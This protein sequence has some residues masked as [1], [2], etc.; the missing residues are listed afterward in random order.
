MTRTR[1]ILHTAKYSG[2]PLDLLRQACPQGFEVKTLDEATHEQ[3]IQEASEAQFFLVSGRLPIDKAVLDNAPHLKMIQR[4]GVGTEMLDLEEIKRRGIPVYVNAGVNARSVAEHT[5]TLIL[6]ALKR[7]P[8]INQQVHQGIW[9][10]QQTG[11]T[12]YELYGKTVGLVGMGNIGRMVAGMLQPFGAKV[13]YTDVF[14]QNEKVE[15]ELGLTYCESFSAMLPLC[16]ILSFHCP[17]TKE[18]TEILNKSTLSLMKEGA[19]VVNTA[20]G[21]LIH[22]DDLYE[23]LQSGHLMGAALDTHYEE[24]LKMDCRLMD[25]DNVIMTPHIGGLSH[26]AFSQ[27]LQKAMTNIKAFEEGD[28]ERISKSKLL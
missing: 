20:R 15:A 22:P 19:I 8:Q 12:I 1:L 26:E 14:R 23:A 18:N 13:L 27:M 6:A 24:P 4:T 9:K 21:K 3:L 28:L 16:D 5:L 2:V 11:V 10:K 7:L 25:L 17:L